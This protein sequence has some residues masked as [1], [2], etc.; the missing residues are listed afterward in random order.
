MR[1]A[2]QIQAEAY[3]ARFFKDHATGQW[4]VTDKGG[5]VIARNVMSIAEASRLFCEDQ[6]II[7]ILASIKAEYAPYDT[8]PEF[9]EGFAAHQ[10]RQY[11][12]PYPRSVAAQA[13]DRGLYTA[14]RY[15]RA[16]D[17]ARRGAVVE[18]ARRPR[19]GGADHG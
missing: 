6:V 12:N 2:Y 5:V 9:E 17:A 7:P 4:S 3:G 13:W 14:A 11:R 8:F 16:M 1:D 18:E 19:N 10:K 15:A